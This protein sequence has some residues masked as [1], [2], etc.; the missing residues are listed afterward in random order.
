MPASLGENDGDAGLH[1]RGMGGLLHR[2]CRR[3][4]RARWAPLRGGVHQ[5]RGGAALSG[6][7][8]AGRG[9][10]RAAD[11]RPHPVRALPGPWSAVAPVGGRAAAG[12]RGRLGTAAPDPCRR[13][14]RPRQPD[15]RL[16]VQ[17]IAMAEIP[18]LLLAIGGVSL[19]A[20]TGGGLYWLVPAL[21]GCF[22]SGV[23]DAWVLLVRG[24]PLMG[25]GRAP[26][27]AIPHS[28]S[29]RFASRRWCSARGFPTED[30]A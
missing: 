27:A 19:I 1:R 8:G 26:T 24:A 13:G 30:R 16:L 9:S 25:A 7:A 11:G 10:D 14:S 17:R 20:Q 2:G 15:T 23:F 29:L 5:P 18:M 21:L 6:S 4:G 12:H 22:V 3:G 28:L